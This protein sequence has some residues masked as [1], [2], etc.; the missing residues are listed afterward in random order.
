[1]KNRYAGIRAY[2]FLLRKA[3]SWFRAEVS[4]IHETSSWFRAKV[5]CICETSARIQAEVSRKK[6]RVC[7]E[8]EMNPES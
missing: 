1:M 2:L 3:S 8:F 5:S 4:C 7:Q 6:K